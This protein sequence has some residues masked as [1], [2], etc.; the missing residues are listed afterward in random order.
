MSRLQIRHWLP[1][2][3]LLLLYNVVCQWHILVPMR[4]KDILVRN[5]FESTLLQCY[6]RW[7]CIEIGNGATYCGLNSRP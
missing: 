7:K 6:K 3:P 5:L 2:H 1:N 4:D